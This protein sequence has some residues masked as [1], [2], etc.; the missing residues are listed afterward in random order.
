MI[1]YELQVLSRLP[2]A[3]A[4]IK[5]AVTSAVHALDFPAVRGGLYHALPVE[6]T[7][8]KWA[9]KE[10]V[11]P[12]LTSFPSFVGDV[13]SIP[14]AYFHHPKVDIAFALWNIQLQEK[15]RGGWDYSMILAKKFQF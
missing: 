5:R 7:F 3:Y 11:G 2:G 6:V 9:G 12:L 14:L 15:I 13:E 10:A 1:Q 8:D 4:V